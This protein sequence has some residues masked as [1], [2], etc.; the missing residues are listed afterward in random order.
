M[1]KT[2]FAQTGEIKGKSSQSFQT[3][4]FQYTPEED[5]LRQ[6]KGTLFLLVQVKE[7]SEEKNQA[8]AS[9]LFVTFKE[10]FYSAAGSNLKVLEEALDLVKEFIKQQGAEVDLAAANLWG[11]VLYIAKL[12]DA[13]AI[14]I[15]GHTAKRIEVTKAVS[16]SLQD[17]DN[18]FLAD[19]PFM[20]NADLAFLSDQ[21]AAEDFQDSLKKHTRSCGW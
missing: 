8:L 10:R 9:Q 17:G 19:A 16:G 4:S 5:P 14:L 20:K 12:G 3:F 2:L 15:R 6:M 13:G 7:G 18:V 1:E 21:G 11:S